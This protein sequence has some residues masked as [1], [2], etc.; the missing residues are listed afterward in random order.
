MGDQLSKL[1][2]PMRYS[3]KKSRKFWDIING[4]PEREK[5]TA[6]SL[7]CALQ[8]VECDLRRLIGLEID[9]AERE[10]E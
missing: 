6:Y 1:G 8:N 3:G 7:G 2:I 5:G 9:T 4:L 10:G